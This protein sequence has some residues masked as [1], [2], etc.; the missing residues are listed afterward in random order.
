MPIYLEE[1]FKTS[2]IPT[3]TFVPPNRYEAL[4]VSLRTP[5]RCAI[6]EGPSGIGKTTSVTKLIEELGLGQKVTSFS[7]RKEKD[8]EYINNITNLGDLGVVIIDDFHRLPDPTKEKISNFV[9]LLADEDSKESKIVLIGINK[10]GDRLV[11]FGSD[12]GLRVDVF[13]LE[14]N[15]S[16]KI[17]E[18]ISSGE[19]ALGIK[20]ADQ[21]KIIEAS[22]GSFQ[23]A[24]ML[25]YELC[26][27]GGISQEQENEVEI[28]GRYD[29]V[30][31]TVMES[32]RRIFYKPC[33]DFARG[34][35]LRREGRA[36]Y[37]HILKWL[38]D[39]TDWS[40]DLRDAVKTN[41][42]HRG[43]VGQVVDKGH[44]ENLLADKSKNLDDFF[45][46]Q[47]ETS[48]FTAEDPRIIFYIRMLNWRNF[49]REVGYTTTYFQ[50]NYDIALSFAG[51]DRDVAQNI[52][53]ELSLREVSVF[54]DE[55]EQHRILAQKVEEYLAPIYKTEAAY[56]VPLL[57]KDYPNRIWTKFESDQFKG[58]F[59]ENAVIAVRFKTSA[60]TY[61]HEAH[62]YGSIS[63]D[64]NSD[65]EQQV[66]IIVDT[67]CKRLAEDRTGESVVADSP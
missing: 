24:Q 35:K 65:Q 48:V 29:E 1:V 67:I 23:I 57:S 59:G 11:Q 39:G 12:V 61:F 66:N 47:P 33:V 54:Y 20:L 60:D 9:K 43:S 50:G 45:H 44:L 19:R 8:L 21:D 49:A 17:Q 46:Y 22:H 10:A 26:L 25:C 7:A 34:S 27:S 13:K 64:P 2:G 31:S 30:I 56:V 6:I 40:I 52:F 37:L 63:F 28:S 41:K 16:D 18:L 4:R 62:E 14:S 32:L 55:N 15:P 42:E 53:D 58:R 5:G 51:A 3:H 36:P 38:R